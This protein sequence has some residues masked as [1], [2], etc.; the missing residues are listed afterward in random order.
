MPLKPLTPTIERPK[1][2]PV[3]SEPTAPDAVTKRAR[4]LLDEYLAGGR[5]FWNDLAQRARHVADWPEPQKVAYLAMTHKERPEARLRWLARDRHPDLFA[6]VPVPPEV[7]L[8]AEGRAARERIGLSVEAVPDREVEWVDGW[9]ADV[10]AWAKTEAPKPARAIAAPLRAAFDEA[11][12]AGDMAGA[13]AAY[14]ALS[15]A[16]K[17]YDQPYRAAVKAAAVIGLQLVGPKV[18]AGPKVSYQ[19]EVSR[20]MGDEPVVTMIPHH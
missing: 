7:A 9:C 10:A 3:P 14:R 19:L 6:G 4:E 16:M 15:E 11:F 5:A 18:S 2:K 12:V 1:P 13:Q 8:Y 17:T 20:V